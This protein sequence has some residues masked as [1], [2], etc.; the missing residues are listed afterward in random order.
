MD[1]RS[2]FALIAVLFFL[3]FGHPWMALVLFLLLL[4]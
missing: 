3:L 2:F 1:D 4:L